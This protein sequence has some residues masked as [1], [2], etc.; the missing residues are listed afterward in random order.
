[1]PDPSDI[2]RLSDLPLSGLVACHECDLLMR[3]P[4]LAHGEKAEC[5]RCGYEL[6]AH[7]HNVVERSL[8]LVIAALLL[9]VPANFLPIMQ[10]NLL[11]QSSQDTVWSGVVGLFDTGM[12]GVSAVVFLCSMGIPLLKLLCQLA[13]L[14]TIRLDVGRSYGL[15]LYRIYH[16]LRDWGML[17][18][19]LMGVLVAIVKLADMAAM[20]IGLG[21]VCFISLL[22]VQVWLEVVMSPHQIWQALSGED[23][24]A[25]D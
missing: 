2:D 25:G 10:L 19:Y 18:V 20:T 13:V 8:A 7:R 16:H 23:A 1:M 15:L 6:Y 4:Q 17:E 3:K 9:Y 14:L 11:G 22:L 12:Q 21:L 5:P 24:H